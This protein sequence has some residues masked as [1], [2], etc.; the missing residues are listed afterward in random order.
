MSLVPIPVDSA[1]PPTGPLITGE[2]VGRGPSYKAARPYG[3]NDW[4][5]IYTVA[6]QGRVTYEGR[7]TPLDRGDVLVIRPR[8]PQFYGTAG[9]KFVWHNVW[10]HFIP[11]GELLASLDWPTIA[12]GVMRLALPKDLQPRVLQQFHEMDAF[13]QTAAVH[14]QELALNALERAL[15]LADTANPQSTMARYDPRVRQAVQYLMAHLNDPPSLEALA[16]LVDLSRSRFAKLFERQV[17]QPPGK[18]IEQHRLFRVKQLLEHTHDTLQ[19]IADEMGYSSPFYLS[20]RF[21]AWFGVSPRSYRGRMT[22]P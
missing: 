2:R 22:S 16:Q 17:G 15:L 10:I 19:E 5:A 7:D 14:R 8:T 9:P 12:P 13:S 6:G 3:R 4:L 11:R 1:D 21:K 18:F 20:L